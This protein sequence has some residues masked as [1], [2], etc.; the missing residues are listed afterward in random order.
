M[1]QRIT[2]SRAI[3]YMIG[4]IA[5][6][7]ILGVWPFGFIH[8]SHVSQSMPAEITES[9]SATAEQM[10]AQVFVSEGTSLDSVDILICSDVSGKALDFEILDGE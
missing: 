6:L 5:I 10:Y 4:T 3:S 2:L 7:L 1:N 8:R 9:E